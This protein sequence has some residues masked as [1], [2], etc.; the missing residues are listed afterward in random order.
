MSREA[1]VR[2]WEGAGLRCPALLN[3]LHAYRNGRE[4]NNGYGPTLNQGT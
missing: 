2:F 4:R 3:Y 1:H